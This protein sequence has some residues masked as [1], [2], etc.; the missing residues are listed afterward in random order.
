MGAVFQRGEAVTP[1]T[2][3]EISTGTNYG[4]KLFT[5]VG[6]NGPK[7]L[8]Y[9]AVPEHAKP[10]DIRV[11]D[12]HTGKLVAPYRIQVLLYQIDSDEVEREPPLAPVIDVVSVADVWQDLNADDA[13]SNGE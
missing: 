3:L 6:Y 1:H 10:E 2:G 8:N 7:W 9:C 4:R 13:D 12:Y 11:R 5:A